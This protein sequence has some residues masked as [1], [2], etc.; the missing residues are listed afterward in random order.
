[1]PVRLFVGNLPYEATEAEIREHFATI[2]TVTYCYLP[3]DRETGRP[4]G[5]AFVEYGDDNNAQQAIARLNNQSFRGRPL[6]VKEAQP[7]E[8]RPPGAGPRPYGGPPGAGGPRPSYGGGG[9][10][11]RPF[12]SRDGAGA[13]GAAGPGARGRDFGPDAI[14]L[15]RE[16]SPQRPVTRK[17]AIRVEMEA[18][19]RAASERDMRVLIVRAGDFFGPRAG[20][21]W[22]SQGLIKPGKPVTAI[23][24]PAAPGVGHQWAYLPDVARTMVELLARREQLPAFASFH[25]AGHWDATGRQM[26]EAIQRVAARHG[27]KPR[28]GALPWWLLKLASPFVATLKEMQEM[29][30]LWQRPVRMDNTRLLAVLS[31]EPHTP[32]IDAVETTLRGMGC[33]PAQGSRNMGS[34]SFAGTTP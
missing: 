17:G 8:A 20:N 26:A 15:L 23:S 21:N 13:P 2:G 12:P 29:R 32:L 1:M 18:R 9:G 6:A 11:P 14:P 10:A 4:R 34:S 3:T 33:L 24:N 25:M 16:D 31:R 27:R 22:F 28:I 5:F 19:L 7:R 30:Y